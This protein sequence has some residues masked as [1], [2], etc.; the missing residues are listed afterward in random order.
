MNRV[1]KKKKKKSLHPLRPILILVTLAVCIYIGYQYIVYG[2]LNNVVQV[3][4]KINIEN[5]NL[6]EPSLSFNNSIEGQILVEN[7]DGY[8]TTFTTLNT[9]YQKTYKEYKQNMDSSWADN[10]YW[11]GTMRKNGCGITTMAIIASGYG[12]DITPEDLREK[13]YPHLDGEKMQDALKEL[14]FKCTDFCFHK[15]YLNKKYILDWLKTNRPVIVCLG[16]KEKNEW[17]ESSHYMALL[18]VNDKGLVYVSNPNGLDGE[19]RASRM[20]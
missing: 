14:G 18:D 6:S 8:T 10:S 7:Q 3:L 11:G 1:Y 19:E 13:Y 17:T 4:S 2:N 12:L 20:V 15:S 5:V 9:E 16:S